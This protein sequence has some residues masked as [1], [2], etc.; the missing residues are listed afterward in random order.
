MGSDGLLAFGTLASV[1]ALKGGD[2]VLRYSV[3]RSTAELLYL[4]I[5]ARVKLQVK[6]FIDTVIWRIGDGL[7]A[8][9]VLVFAT[10]LHFPPRQIICIVL[11]LVAGCLLTAFLPHPHYSP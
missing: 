11:L 7:S 8:V 6:W 1:V 9:I 10:F 2:T 4:P 5:A 3:D